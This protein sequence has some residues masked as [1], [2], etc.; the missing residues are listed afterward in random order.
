V[1]SKL[2][3]LIVQAYAERGGSE[4]W[5]L[6]LIDATDELDLSA[7]LLKDGPLHG[8]LEARGIPVVVRPVGNNPLDLLRPI[9]WLARSLRR[10]APDVILANVMKAQLVAGPAGRIVG[11]PTVWA[12]HDHGYDRLLAVPLGRISDRVVGAVEELAAPTKRKDAI[13]IP[14]PLP[15]P[16][17][18]R[19]EARAAMLARGIPLDNHPALVMAGRLVPFKGVDD[20]IRALVRSEAATWTLFVAGE[21]DHSAPGETD[22]LRSIAASSGV[23]DRVWFVGHVPRISHWLQAFDALAVLTRP[24]GRRAPK[25]EGFGTSAFEAQLAG[26][27]VIAT[28]A[29]A[30]V[31][32]LD[33]DR[34]GAAVPAGDSAAVARALARFADPAERARAGAAARSIVANHPDAA[35]CARMLVAVL[36]DAAGRG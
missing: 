8:E 28:G 32:R 35:E 16:P 14:P 9:V 21:D 23:A 2:R 6:H 10:D 18:S 1:S 30:V 26:L 7:V 15:E 20:A 5:L 34:A 31:R 25:S 27:P 29:G 4:S 12:K 22:R 24:G 19:S 36:R 11:V 33:G 17:A 13:I 3:V